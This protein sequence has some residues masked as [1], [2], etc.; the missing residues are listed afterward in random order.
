MVLSEK[1][2]QDSSKK[3][4]RVGFEWWMY[5]VIGLLIAIFSVARIKANV[6]HVIPT[7]GFA[8]VPNQPA[9]FAV[10][11]ILGVS[12]LLRRLKYRTSLRQG[13]LVVL[14]AALSAVGLVF[15]SGVDLIP[16]IL[17][18][19]SRLVNFEGMQKLAPILERFPHAIMP[20][21]NEIVE[22]FW[23]GS[24]TV[25]WGAWVVPLLL[26]M[27]FFALTFILV[28]CSVSLVFDQWSRVERLGFPL[29]APVVRIIKPAG[30]SMGTF[31]VQ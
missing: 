26:W 30:V 4:V 17:M 29:A 14:Y 18:T 16:Y 7:I 15:Q 31:I 27:V 9:L 1:N 22:G 13:H 20:K 6:L 21:E 3:S 11:L 5:V 24:S 25:P 8:S 2:V 19:W 28:V 10:V 12:A 23:I